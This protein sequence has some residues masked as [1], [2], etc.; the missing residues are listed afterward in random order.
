MPLAPRAVAV[1][2]R[3]RSPRSG[4][5]QTPAPAHACAGLCSPRWMTMRSDFGAVPSAQP[6]IPCSF[7]KAALHGKDQPLIQQ[8]TLLSSPPTSSRWGCGARDRDG[9]TA[10]DAARCVRDRKPLIARRDQ[11]HTVREGHRT[12]IARLGRCNRRGAS[13]LG[14]CRWWRRPRRPGSWYRRCRSGP[15]LPQ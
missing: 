9:R 15:R 14:R 7:T 4:Y 8:C 13:R 1:S 5:S 12:A 3:E 2:F 11:R 6:L 10:S